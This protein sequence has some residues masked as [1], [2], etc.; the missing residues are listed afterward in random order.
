MAS[1][2]LNVEDSSP[3]FSYSP[4]GA[5]ADSPNNDTLLPSY[6]GSSLHVANAP[7]AT[8]TISFSGTGI[9]IFGGNRPTYGQYTITVDG[10]VIEQGNAQSQTAASQVLLGTT[11]G[12]TNG[13]HTAVITCGTNGPIDVDFVTI[14][15]QIGQPGSQ[16]ISTTIDDN[17]SSFS[18][19]PSPSD[20]QANTG[21]QFIDNSE[22]DST[23][24]GAAAQ[25]TISGDAFA[26]YGTVSP[27]NA[28]IQVSV[29]GSLATVLNGGS[30][31][32]FASVAHPQTLLYYGANLGPGQHTLNIAAVQGQGVGNTLSV[33]AVVVYSTSGDS[34]DQGTG[35]GSTPSAGN[36]NQLPDIASNTFAQPSETASQSQAKHQT[37]SLPLPIA[38]IAGIAAGAT[39]ILIVFLVLSILLIRRRN[40]QRK[41]EM[42]AA[43][44]GSPVLPIQKL[45]AGFLSPV[46]ETAP[47]PL[48]RSGSGIVLGGSVRGSVY[49]TSS[50]AYNGM[51]SRGE[52]S[53]APMSDVPK[54]KLPRPPPALARPAMT[55]TG[56]VR[57]MRPP[58]FNLPD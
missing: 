8:A 49:S 7:G 46:V 38:A 50:V 53:T 51:P 4:G 55:K 47:R 54:L 18:Y 12:L 13:P 3:L 26:V 22:H 24:N 2:P 29:D 48:Y 33:D 16:M 28:N 34:S 20:W 36:N 35:T 43:E 6:S 27:N 42:M 9:S 57:P 21:T 37:Q 5:W 32:G 17:G 58:T 25:V 41:Y 11:T 10:T 39:V 15:N 19:L 30:V 52:M 14:Q 45:E 23:T 44:P 1:F 56:P 31:G 40:A